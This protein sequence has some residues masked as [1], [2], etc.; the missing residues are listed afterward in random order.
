MPL[1]SRWV[2]GHRDIAKAKTK[3]ERTE[4]KRNDEA[5]RPAKMATGLP[6]HGYTTTHPGYIAVN[7][8]LAKN[9]I[10]ERRHNLFS[11]TH[12]VSWLPLKGTSRMT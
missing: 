10:I 5:D 6:L 12:W 8:S 3:E 4:I 11:R 9:W 7:G 2:P 1:P